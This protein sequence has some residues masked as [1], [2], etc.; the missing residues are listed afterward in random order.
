[1]HCPLPFSMAGCFSKIWVFFIF[2]FKN[3]ASIEII[4]VRLTSSK[5]ARPHF[6]KIHPDLPTVKA[7]FFL[8]GQRLTF[9]D[10]CPCTTACPGRWAMGTH[11]VQ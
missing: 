4:T 11:R 8:G 6:D 3:L 5:A 1:M 10:R 9:R 2:P 7:N